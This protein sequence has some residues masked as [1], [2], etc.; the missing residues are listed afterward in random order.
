[1][2]WLSRILILWL[3]KFSI[4]LRW[5]LVGTFTFILDYFLFL[6]LYENLKSVLFANMVSASIANAANYLAHHGWTFKSLQDHSSS[7]TRY[8]INFLFWWIVSSTIIKS[9]IIIDVDPKVAKIAPIIIIAPI[10]F[11]VLKKIVFKK[12]T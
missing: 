10:N 4:H 9:L 12:K 11:F 3:S 7:G 1:M 8:I 2:N 5:G 6:Q